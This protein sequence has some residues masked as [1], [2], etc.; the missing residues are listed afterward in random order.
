MSRTVKDDGGRKETRS[1]GLSPG[2]INRIEKSVK[3]GD[4]TGKSDVANTAFIEHFLLE[5]QRER[6]EKLYKIYDLLLE[7][8]PCEAI[9]KEL[10]ISKPGSIE[11]L[12]K[13][14][15][16]CVELGDLEEARECFRKAKELEEQDSKKPDLNI[17]NRII[18]E[19]G[20]IDREGTES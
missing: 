13:K 1:F 3:N 19:N 8:T 4:Y 17:N 16:A 7:N 6:D 15:I 12:K 10:Q 18:V 11:A 14:G 5:D 9:L 2:V 20:I